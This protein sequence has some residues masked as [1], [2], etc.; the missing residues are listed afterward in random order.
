[1]EATHSVFHALAASMWMVLRVLAMRVS[2]SALL[3]AGELA[4]SFTRVSAHSLPWMHS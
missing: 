3:G 1:M 4:A 2:S